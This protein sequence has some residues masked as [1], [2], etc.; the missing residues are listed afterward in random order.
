MIGGMHLQQEDL[1]AIVQRCHAARIANRGG[2]SH[3]K[4]SFRRG[5]ARPTTW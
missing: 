4:Q 3:Y 5:A 1:I 2:R